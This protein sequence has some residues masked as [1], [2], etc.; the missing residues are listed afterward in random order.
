M[1]SA[2]VRPS[3]GRACAGA[4]GVTRFRA[5]LHGE[6]RGPR[7]G[8]GACQGRT[9]GGAAEFLFGWDNN[10]VRPPVFPV[11]VGALVSAEKTID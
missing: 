1:H 8:M 7:C 10:S 6:A 3:V 4:P 2:S 11:N 5:S 9:G